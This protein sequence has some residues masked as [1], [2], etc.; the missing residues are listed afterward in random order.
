[1][2]S[3]RL[4]AADAESWP[5][6]S[7][8]EQSVAPDG[9]PHRLGTTKRSGVGGGAKCRRLRHTPSRVAIERHL[10][11][12]YI[13]LALGMSMALAVPKLLAALPE[14]IANLSTGTRAWKG[15]RRV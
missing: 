1:M 12:S 4:Q 13:S 6:G 15:G 10:S 8:D 11:F 9:Q 3:A 14:L 7:F 2:L 5:T